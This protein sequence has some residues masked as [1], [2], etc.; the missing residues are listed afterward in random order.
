VN[1]IFDLDGLLINSEEL[2]FAANRIYFAKFGLS[3]SE[4]LHRK[5]TGRNFAEWIKTVF[6]I[7]L[8][9]TAILEGRNAIYY[10]LAATRLRLM[11]GARRLL[12]RAHKHGATALVTSSRRGYVDFI[13]HHVD[14][15]GSFDVVI[16][17]DMVSRS[18]PDPESYLLAA[19]KLGVE[20]KTCV[21]FEDS[22][23]GVKAARGAGM[24]V[25]VVPSQ[26]VTGDVMFG[27]A[28]QVLENLAEY[29]VDADG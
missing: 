3:F 12:N 14:V 11:P 23:S 15:R 28:D 21:V 13:F 16:T 1:Y 4:E 10:E 24:K 20:S 8:D 18:K 17:G 19:E 29:E 5:G 22:P 25:V 2:Y 26:Y 6:D 9:G 27:R 7:R